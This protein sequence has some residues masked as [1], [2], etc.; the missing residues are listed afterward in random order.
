MTFVDLT[1][2]ATVQLLLLI[3][4]RLS[5]ILELKW[6]HV[7]LVAGTLALPYQKGCGREP[8]P[9]ATAALDVLARRSILTQPNP[10]PLN[11]GRSDGTPRAPL[12]RQ[13]GSRP[14]CS[15]IFRHA[16]SFV[17]RAAISSGCESSMTLSDEC[18]NV[19]LLP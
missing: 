14:S 4:A 3:G 2:V 17:F 13:A 19:C 15:Q 5:E 7:D 6:D 1:A 12:E 11:G 9:V 18:I 8:Y 16:R 10:G